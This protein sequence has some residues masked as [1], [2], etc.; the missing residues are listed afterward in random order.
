MD[1]QEATKRSSGQSVSN[2]SK[3]SKSRFVL[4]I[5]TAVFFFGNEGAVMKANPPE[6]AAVPINVKITGAISHTDHTPGQNGTITFNRFPATVKEFQQ[7][8]DQIGGEPHGAVALQIMAYEMYRR[9]KKIGEECITLNSVRTTVQSSTRRLNELYGK[10]ANYARPYQMAAYLKDA[11]PENGYSP[12]KP[13]T[14]EVQVD[15][16][17]AYQKSSIFQTDVLYLKVLTNGKDRGSVGVAV[18]KTHDPNQPSQG[19]YFIIF[20][21]SNLYTQV[22]AVSFTSPFKGLD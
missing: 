20:E 5:A 9:N 1:N 10:D 8:R 22:K 7:V 21:S 13:Y 15:N 16:V 6:P 14:I 18:L 3:G 11:T 4:L 2:S 19:K 12:S 17:N